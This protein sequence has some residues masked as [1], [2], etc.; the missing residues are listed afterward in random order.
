[1]AERQGQ[2]FRHLRA[3]RRDQAE[4]PRRP[5]G[6]DSSQTDRVLCLPVLR[7]L[8]VAVIVVVVVLV[9]RVYRSDFLSSS[10]SSV[11]LSLGLA[12][13]RQQARRM[14]KWS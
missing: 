14:A 10:S 6:K 3:E 7:D 11:A 2:S 1:L 4:L 5:Q 12:G 8:G 9:L 13:E